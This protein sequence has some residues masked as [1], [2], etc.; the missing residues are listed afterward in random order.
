MRELLFRAYI[1]RTIYVE[2]D[3]YTDTEKEV[4]FHID[5]VA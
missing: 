5:G 2:E 1:T 4:K 3:G